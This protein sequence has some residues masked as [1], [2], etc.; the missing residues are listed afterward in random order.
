MSRSRVFQLASHFC[1]MVKIIS[2]ANLAGEGKILLVVAV[3]KLCATWLDELVNPEALAQPISLDW[4]VIPAI[5][6]SKPQEEW[7]KG[8]HLVQYSTV[9]LRKPP[10][11]LP[12]TEFSPGRFGSSNLSVKRNRSYGTNS[13]YS[14]P[15]E[16]LFPVVKFVKDILYVPPTFASM[17]WTMQVKPLGGN[18]LAMVPGY[19][20]IFLV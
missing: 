2:P 7:R 4:W 14:P 5:Q 6:G 18:H 3:R 17:W 1:I 11:K 20:H 19:Q 9:S 8:S 12:L 16:V 13:R 15:N 10:S